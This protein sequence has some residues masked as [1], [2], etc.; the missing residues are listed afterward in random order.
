MVSLTHDDAPEGTF[1]YLYE[2]AHRETGET[3]YGSHKF[4]STEAFDR[5]FGSGS[6]ITKA[7]AKEGKASFRKKI[8]SFHTSGEELLKAEEERHALENAS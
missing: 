2:I 3:Y 4:S 1:G 6:R 8:V 7:V 5:Y